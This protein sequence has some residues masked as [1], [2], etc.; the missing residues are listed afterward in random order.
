MRRDFTC[1]RPEWVNEG[2]PELR[3]SEAILPS[4]RQGEISY[5]IH[6]SVITEK[7]RLKPIVASD[8]LEATGGPPMLEVR[9]AE[10]SD[11]W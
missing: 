6:G 5:D 11:N 9:Y 2:H 10:L 7:V 8:E 4:A 1:V 3:S